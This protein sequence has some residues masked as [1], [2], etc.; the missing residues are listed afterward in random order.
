MLIIEK[1]TETQLMEHMMC[2]NGI[3]SADADVGKETDVTC[4]D[5]MHLEQGSPKPGVS[6]H[7]LKKRERVDES[8]ELLPPQHSTLVHSFKK[9]RRDQGWIGMGREMS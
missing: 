1:E 7:L 8:L 3:S 4:R 5:C 2:C 6:F 9:C